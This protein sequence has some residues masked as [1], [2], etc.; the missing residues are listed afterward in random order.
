VFGGPPPTPPQHTDP[1]YNF[2][3]Y[4]DGSQ[5]N[6]PLVEPFCRLLTDRPE[7]SLEPRTPGAWAELLKEMLGNEWDS[8]SPLGSGAVGRCFS[9]HREILELRLKIEK[10]KD[11]KRGNLYQL[12]MRSAA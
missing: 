8:R 2:M 7:L 3:L 9:R 6:C 1:Y 10:T 12:A 11:T 4:V 5:E